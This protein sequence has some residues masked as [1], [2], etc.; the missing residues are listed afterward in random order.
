LGQ[1][2]EE[3]GGQKGRAVWMQGSASLDLCD[4]TSLCV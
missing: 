3:E 2:Y 1:I 4:H